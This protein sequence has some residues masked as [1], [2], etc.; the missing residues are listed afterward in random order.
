M[1]ANG[2]ITT[3]NEKQKGEGYVLT[4]MPNSKYYG[5]KLTENQQ[6]AMLNLFTWMLYENWFINTAQDEDDLK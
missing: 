2:N 3:I 6:A 5:T 4:V 1:I